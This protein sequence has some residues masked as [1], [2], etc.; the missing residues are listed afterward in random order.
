VTADTLGVL[1]VGIAL[2]AGGTTI[3]QLLIEMFTQWMKQTIERAIAEA[4]K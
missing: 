3:L 4:K 2:G 1:I